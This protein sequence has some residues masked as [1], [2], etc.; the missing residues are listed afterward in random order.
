MAAD[1]EDEESGDPEEP[2]SIG[3]AKR[4]PCRARQL[5][6]STPSG[7]TYTHE[8]GCGPFLAI[9]KYY[10]WLQRVFW[11]SAVGSPDWIAVTDELPR[12]KMRLAFW[13]RNSP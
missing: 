4:G 12:V 1:S 7:L 2:P 8:P 13:W 11:L 5:T 3:A 9:V 10:A 6:R